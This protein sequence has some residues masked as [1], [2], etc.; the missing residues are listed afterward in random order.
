MKVK[1]MTAQNSEAGAIDLPSQF[2]EDVR[3]D[4]IARAV[5]AIQA[6][7]RQP[8]GGYGNAG[9]RHSTKISRRRRDFKGSY[10]KGISRVPR[11]IHTH[12][13]M[14]FGWVGALSP[15]TVGGR[16]AHP[17]KPFKEW[18]QKVNTGENRKAIR[19]ALSATVDAKMVSARGHKLPNTFPFIIDDAFETLTKT[20]DLQAALVRLG[21]A[22]E[23]VRA[24]NIG[25]RAGRGKS[26]GRR[27]KTPTS[28]LFVVSK[29]ATPLVKAAANLSGT[30]V[31]AVHRVNAALLAPGTHAG[32]LT[33]YTKAAVERLAKEGLFLA[34]YKGASGEKKAVKKRVN[35][36]PERPKKAARPAPAVNAVTKPAAK[37]AAKK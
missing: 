16:A 24:G 13:G 6:A 36:V 32:R 15:G 12:R 14:Q 27:Y 2:K 7:G 29:D 5:L 35:P 20:A 31:I 19:S 33:L 34:G 22:E 1:V 18:E 30:D 3:D 37:A 9:M 8:Y 28:V 21:F 17:P 4:L 23:L 26:R 25:I 10:G 11:K